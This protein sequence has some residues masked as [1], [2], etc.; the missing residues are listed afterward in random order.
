MKWLGL[1]EL[2]VLLQQVL[3]WFPSHFPFHQVKEE[4]KMKGKINLGVTKE[5]LR[6]AC[7]FYQLIKEAFLSHFKDFES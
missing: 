6:F 4:E 2:L 5:E 3:C 7:L 1:R